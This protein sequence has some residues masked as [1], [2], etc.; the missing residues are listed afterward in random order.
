MRQFLILPF[1]LFS[2]LFSCNEKVL[3]AGQDYLI[4]SDAFMQK[5]VPGQSDATTKDY[6]KIKLDIKK[7]AETKVTEIIFRNK[8]YEINSNISRLKLNLAKG[9]AT[10]NKKSLKDDQAIIYYTVANKE[11]VVTV[12]NIVTKPPV[13]LP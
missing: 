11:Y 12:K 13:F 9:K 6:L 2:F 1:V 8:S 4:I 7:P 10:N 5:E 3:T